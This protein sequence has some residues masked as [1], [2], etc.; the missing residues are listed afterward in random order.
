MIDIEEARE[1]AL[2]FPEAEEQDHWGRPSFRVRKRI[3]ATLWPQELRA[4]LKLPRPLQLAL[5]AAEPA[6]YSMG[7][8]Q[9][10]GWTG[11][12]LESVSREAFAEYLEAAWREVAPKS[13]VKNYD[14]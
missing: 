4:M 7:P 2:S 5:V 14:G 9:N 11:V 10:Q 1:L 8:W 12:A 13:A 6:V 3:F